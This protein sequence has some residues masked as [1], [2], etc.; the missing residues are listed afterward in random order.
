[1]IN[2]KD[3]LLQKLNEVTD[4][5]ANM[6]LKESGGIRKFEITEDEIVLLEVA[7]KNRRKDETSI[8]LALVKIVKI[9]FGYPG[10]R[11]EFTDN[12]IKSSSNNKITYIALSSG[13]GGVG[14]SSVTALLALAL[15][16]LG[17]QVGIID[18]DVYGPSIP[19]LF[20]LPIVPLSTDQNDQI[21]PVNIDGIEIVS[22]EFFMPKDQPMMWR[23]PMLGKILTHFFDQV[24][25]DFETKFILVDL[26]PGTGDVQLDLKE[27]M[28]DTDFI[29]ITTPNE[30]ATHVA[31]KA[32]L[33]AIE[34]G[35]GVI[36]VIENMS[37]LID[38]INN[39]E[40]RF[41]FGQ[42]GGAELS[43]LL[44]VDLLGSLPYHIPMGSEN[45]L[46]SKDDMIFKIMIVIATKLIE[47]YSK[48]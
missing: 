23:G 13:K 38:E 36:G 39:N 40:R 24:A 4:L 33:G 9:D 22:T 3:E 42:G 17:I 10:I 16:H 47:K 25:W 5:S 19:K 45:I 44:G 43:E 37:Y 46:P 11:I 29:V 1:M 35:Q 12:K 26:P 14:K 32:G 41:I 18:A 8:K 28:P 20:N 6:T 2:K 31:K 27:F 48:Q 21:I 7:L 15:K 34:I 30:Q